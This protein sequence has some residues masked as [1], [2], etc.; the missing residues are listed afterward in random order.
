MRAVLGVAGRLRTRFDRRWNTIQKALDTSL[1]NKGYNSP[2]MQGK[3]SSDELTQILKRYTGGDA[4]L[5]RD[6]E[7]LV[8]AVEIT[9][10][11]GERGVTASEFMH[12]MAKPVEV[13]TIHAGFDPLQSYLQQVWYHKEPPA[14]APADLRV[15]DAG[16]KA[17]DRFATWVANCG[18]SEAAAAALEDGPG[19]SYRP[20]TR[21]ALRQ[22]LEELDALGTSREKIG[23]GGAGP[24]LLDAFL[25][26]NCQQAGEGGLITPVRHFLISTKAVVRHRVP[27]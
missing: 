14:S 20:S 23:A 22:R 3:V 11:G 26:A 21:D 15:A 27:P 5:E 1:M 18:G 8:A 13:T 24:G 2:F 12:V 16:R 9:G 17:A 4:Q 10:D 25:D 19:G 7:A 6:A